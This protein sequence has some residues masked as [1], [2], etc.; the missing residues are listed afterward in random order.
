VSSQVDSLLRQVKSTM[1]TQSHGYTIPP[2]HNPTHA[3]KRLHPSLCSNT[4]I[5][6][7]VQEEK[8]KQK[9]E[10]ERADAKYKTA[11][12]DGRAEPVRMLE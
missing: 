10:K 4:C 8:I 7:L 3:Q 5:H 9:E 11:F 12:V 6:T 1:I 2:A